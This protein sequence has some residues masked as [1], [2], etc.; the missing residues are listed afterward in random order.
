MEIVG[1]IGTPLIINAATLK[2]AFG[3]YARML[4]DIDFYHRLF[5]EIMVER[6]GFVF[7]VEVDYEWLPNFCMRC[8]ILGH[9]VL[10]C[11][12]LH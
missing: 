3:H 9:S 1:A 4:V 11:R 8:Q 10:N 6:E 5:Y 12:W 7:H 2:R